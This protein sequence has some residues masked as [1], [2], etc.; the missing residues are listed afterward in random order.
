[1][2]GLLRTP[3]ATESSKASFFFLVGYFLVLILVALCVYLGEFEGFGC[4]HFK[5][6]AT[7]IADHDV[8]FFYFVGIEIKY[9]LAFLTNWHTAL[10]SRSIK[11][12]MVTAT[13][14]RLG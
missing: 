13:Q 3:A 8:A 11:M 12:L 4:D 7:L 6:G 5:L 10:L 2:A 14:R 9:A 1:V